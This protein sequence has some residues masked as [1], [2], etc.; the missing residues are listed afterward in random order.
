MYEFLEFHQSLIFKFLFLIKKGDVGAPGSQGVQGV[1]GLPGK[2]G[3]VGKMG[4]QGALINLNSN[5]F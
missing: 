4:P 3:P 5:S 1:R 2:P